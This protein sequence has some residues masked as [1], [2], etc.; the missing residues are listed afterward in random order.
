M[1]LFR[2][3]EDRS[4]CVAFKLQSVARLL[5]MHDSF[6]LKS[7]RVRLQGQRRT[8]SSQRSK[9]WVRSGA[10]SICLFSTGL[11][12]DRKTRLINAAQAGVQNTW[13]KQFICVSY[14]T[15]RRKIKNLT[16]MTC[17]CYT[18]KGGKVSVK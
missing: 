13:R 5:I 16:G 6:S 1:D 17:A 10:R 3:L 11:S 9:R 12:G 2:K 18:Q 15:Y 4:E 8:A 7:N 14:V